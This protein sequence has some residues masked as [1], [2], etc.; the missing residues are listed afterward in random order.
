MLCGAHTNQKR[1]LAVSQSPYERLSSVASLRQ[2]D[3]PLHIPSLKLAKLRETQQLP[4]PFE[5]H[6]EGIS[7]V[8]SEPS[9]RTLR[10]TALTFHSQA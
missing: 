2:A 1:L 3:A 10:K 5:R 9:V 4:G 7:L 6:H 8:E